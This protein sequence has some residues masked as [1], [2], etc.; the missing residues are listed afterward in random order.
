MIK[1]YDDYI[2]E[3]I[4]TTKKPKE[5][6][7]LGDVVKVIDKNATFP[8][9]KGKV[10]SILG[11]LFFIKTVNGIIPYL[12]S[13][14]QLVERNPGKK[15][16]IE[17]P[18]GEEDWD[19]ERWNESVNESKSAKLKVGDVITCIK[20]HILVNYGSGKHHL[21]LTVGK[22]YE[23]MKI[24]PSWKTGEN[25]I[26]IIPDNSKSIGNYTYD[27]DIFSTDKEEIEKAKNIRKE[28]KKKEKELKIQRGIKAL[29]MK[30]VDP[31]GEEDWE[32]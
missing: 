4:F 1:K 19:E 20:D 30:E 9:I 25:Y 14:L 13:G 8:G 21:G 26:W 23:I 2:T 24:S 11:N 7:E 27:K 32:D 18:Y 10:H 22:D 17:D 5:N 29:K 15:I 12:M 31:Y 6:I 3:G 16:T 28:E